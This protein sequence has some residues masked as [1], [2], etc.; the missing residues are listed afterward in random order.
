M[1]KTYEKRYKEEIIKIDQMN[2]KTLKNYRD[3][4]INQLNK[5]DSE[6]KLLSINDNNIGRK[7]YLKGL[8][9]NTIEPL[10]SYIKKRQV[11]INRVV[12]NGITTK[13]SISFV[14]IASEI[15]PIDL[16][17]KIYGLALSKEEKNNQ[18]IDDIKKFIK[19]CE[20]KE[21]NNI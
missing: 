13:F 5:I 19:E 6:I 7:K 9:K 10:L 8:R 17:Q 1:T 4:T 21:I 14:K 18:T 11:L 15:L 12:N 2:L 20:D 16:F 3:I